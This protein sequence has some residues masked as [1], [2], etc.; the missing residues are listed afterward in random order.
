MPSQSRT[1]SRRGELTA[2]L[3][4]LPF[5]LAAVSVYKMR[6]GKVVESQMFHADT[7]AILQF[8]KAIN[9]DDVSPSAD[10]A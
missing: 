10:A 5:A 8:L 1:S 9:D 2:R 6:G 7:A 3:A 4:E